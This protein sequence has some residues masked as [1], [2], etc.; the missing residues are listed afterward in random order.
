M[1][2]LVL[3]RAQVVPPSVRGPPCFGYPHI[4][5]RYLGTGSMLAFVNRPSESGYQNKV[6]RDFFWEQ[7]LA[8]PVARAGAA[9][10]RGGEAAAGRGGAP[11]LDQA[12]GE[13]QVRGV[14]EG[15]TL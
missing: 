15:G 3:V 7:A 2:V 8:S 5:A 14:V 10:R 4:Q 9:G 6:N 11:P 12:A 13:Q 1:L